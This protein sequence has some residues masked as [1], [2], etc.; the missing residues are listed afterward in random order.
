MYS[1]QAELKFERIRQSVEGK[2]YERSI[3]KTMF[4]V[5]SLEKASSAVR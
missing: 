4:C 5:N 2:P 3:F 1:V